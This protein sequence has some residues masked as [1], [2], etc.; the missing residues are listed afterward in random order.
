MHRIGSDLGLIVVEDG[1]QDFVGKARR[2]TDH[3]L[4]AAGKVAVLLVGLGL[5]V[6]VLQ[7]LAVIDAHFGVDARILGRFQAREY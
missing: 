1:G 6:H 7:A 2:H 3:S 5:G 4:V